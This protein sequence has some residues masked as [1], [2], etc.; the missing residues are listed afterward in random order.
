MRQSISSPQHGAGTGP[1][2]RLL[3]ESATDFFARV[4]PSAHFLDVSP[5]CHQLTGWSPD[6]LRGR[7]MR[8]MA[9][10]DD[11]QQVEVAH[12]EALGAAAASGAVLRMRCKDGSYMWLE[13]TALPLRDECDRITEFQVVFRDVTARV[14]GEKQLVRHAQQHAALARLG[15][16][17]L[18]EHD[19]SK[20]V[21]EVVATVTSTLAVELCGVLKLREDED[22]LDILAHS[23]KWNAELTKLSFETTQAGYALTRREP[24]VSEDLRS[25]TRFN[26]S[27]LLANGMLS[28]MDAL[29]GGDERPFGVLSAHSSEP[30]HFNAD[31][32]NFLVAVANVVSA[33]AE[34]HRREDVTRHASLHDP[35]TGL[36]NRTLALDRIDRAL[37]RRRREGIDVAMM[38]IDLDRFKVV[39]DSLGH[40]A[41]DELLVALAKRLQEAVRPSDTVARLGGDEFLVVCERAGGVRQVLA[42]AERLTAAVSQPLQLGEHQH[43][44]SASIGIAI[45]ERTDSTAAALLR[46]ADAAMYRAKRRG[47]GLVELFNAAMRAQ[48]LARLRT[49]TELRQA[50]DR[51]ELV[52]HYQ[53]IL[54]VATGQPI[55]TEALVR[56]E[57]PHHGLIAPLDFIPIAEETDLILELGRSVLEKACQQ[58]AAWQERFRMPLQIFV[59]V[60]GRQLTKRQFASEAAE[61]ARSSGLQAGTLAIEV[62]ESMLIDET[63]STVEVLQS[64]HSHGL[65]LLLDDFGTGYSSL[66]YL[67]RFPLD[68]VKV[69]RSFID[70]LG[71]G[72]EDVAIMRAIVEMCGVLGLSVVAEGVESDAQLRHLRELGCANAQGYLLCRPMPAPQIS[73]FLK[74]RLVGELVA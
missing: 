71:D 13:S 46:D 63:D 2:Y 41:G 62:T 31:D 19:L 58:G 12:A 36:P 17:A 9:H 20:L 54:D 6:E 51:D 29:I 21:E 73:A 39:N 70:G 14:R 22:S 11:L 15:Q 43:F 57:H 26:A 16:F 60:S 8:D 67:R 37:A 49:E 3:V 68:G 53:P 45:P 42:L 25:E 28:G 1:D 34:R 65:R 30:R 47:P 66:S 55:A 59:N 33:A 35:L 5:K 4:S 7:N 44:S 38:M 24:V 56:W 69:D 32:V 52:L 72:P 64:L 74:R 48:L 23:G 10:P 27:R 40:E 61:V 18:G 50:V